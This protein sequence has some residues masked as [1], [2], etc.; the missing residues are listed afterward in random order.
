MLI[1]LYSVYQAVL[2]RG[3]PEEERASSERNF[4]K[5]CGSML[6]LYDKQWYDI[7]HQSED[8][9]SSMFYS[10]PDLIHPFASSVDSPDLAPPK[11]IVSTSWSRLYDSSMII[12]I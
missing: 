1:F 8:L 10:R 3:T 9:H 5:L 12:Y 7:F 6:W 11:Q 2:N 4:C